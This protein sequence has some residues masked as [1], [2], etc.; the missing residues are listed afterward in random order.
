MR[1]TG[2]HRSVLTRLGIAERFDLLCRLLT[3]NCP[4]LECYAQVVSWGFLLS[5]PYLTSIGRFWTTTSRT[6]LLE[7]ELGYFLRPG[8]L[9]HAFIFLSSVRRCYS[10]CLALF[11]LLVCLRVLHPAS[12]INSII[13][14]PRSDLGRNE[15]PI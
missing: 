11:E 1:C 10:S 13:S 6:S 4:I 8:R 9:E 15:Q 2:L 3:Y 7:L 5:I 14:S 12:P